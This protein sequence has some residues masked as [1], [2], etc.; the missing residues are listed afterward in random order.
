MTNE[1]FQELVLQQLKGLADRM[2]SIDEG[3]ARL[4]S[5]METVEKGQARLEKRLEGVEKGQL[6]LETRVE[7]EVIDKIRILFDA[8]MLQNDWYER[9]MDLLD[10]VSTDVRYLVARVAKLEKIAK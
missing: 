5:R 2:E 4:D 7:N 9:I 1:R 3:Q 6:R 10:D 8:N